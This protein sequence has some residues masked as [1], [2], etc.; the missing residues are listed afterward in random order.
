MIGADLGRGTVGV[1]RIAPAEAAL[2]HRAF[3]V[4]EQHQHP[5]LVGLQGEEARSQDASDHKQDDAR[6]HQPPD[7]ARAGRT[8][9]SQDTGHDQ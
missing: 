2:A 5:R 1:E 3:V 9:V 8:L 4:A 7:G 6:Y